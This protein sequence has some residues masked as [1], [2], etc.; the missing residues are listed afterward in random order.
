MSGLLH[1]LNKMQQREGLQLVWLDR[2]PC[3]ASSL[4]PR[5]HFKKIATG[6][7]T[8]EFPFVSVKTR[9]EGQ[10]ERQG[11]RRVYTEIKGF[12]LFNSIS[13]HIAS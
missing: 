11:L 1:T 2:I 7:R 3:H 9:T 10:T 5:G 4:M 12:G 6:I 8:L 13:L